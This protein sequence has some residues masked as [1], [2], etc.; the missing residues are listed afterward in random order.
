VDQSSILLNHEFCIARLSAFSCRFFYFLL[1]TL[2]IRGGSIRT[3]LQGAIHWA[4]P[5]YLVPRAEVYRSPSADTAGQRRAGTYLAPDA[6]G[7][8]KSTSVF[9]LPDSFAFQNSLLSQI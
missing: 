7:R 1:V 8:G 9:D 2:R 6:Q 5:K 4:L 3:R